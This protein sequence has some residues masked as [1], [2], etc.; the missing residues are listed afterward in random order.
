[1]SKA[2]RGSRS[3]PARHEPPSRPLRFYLASLHGLSRLYYG[4]STVHK[5]LWLGFLSDRSLRA[6][7]EYHYRSTEGGES[8][9][10][11]YFGEEFNLT[12]LRYW[13]RTSLDRYFRDCRSVLV[14]AA[15][16]GR[17]MLALARRC[18]RVDGFECNDRLADACRRFLQSQGVEARVLDAEPDAVPD[19]LGVYDGALLGWCALMH[20]VG[21]RN[22]IELLSGFHQHLEP[23]GPL[24]LSVSLRKGSI[25]VRTTHRVANAIRFLLRREPVE[26]GDRITNTFDHGT[27][28]DEL[29]DELA[30]AGFEMVLFRERLM[31]AHVVAL[32]KPAA[33]D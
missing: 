14:G 3:Q 27:T 9:D 23:G 8:Q 20:V 33:G 19:D 1:M 2:E 17:E 7:T 11:D 28:H 13:E 25:S 26:V 6:L 5:A 22:R 29:R 10:V 24:L 4:V 31:E 16:G 12:G 30:E 15:G 32:A 21:R 18:E